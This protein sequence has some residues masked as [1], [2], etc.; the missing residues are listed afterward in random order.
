MDVFI[1]QTALHWLFHL[2]HTSLCC[3]HSSMVTD[4]AII[5]TFT[6]FSFC[7]SL[8]SHPWHEEVPRLGVESELQLPAQ[9]TAY[10]TAMWDPSH[11]CEL[12]LSS[13]QRRILIHRARPRI[14]PE[15]SWML[16]GFI[17]RWA[18]MGTC[19]YMHFSRVCA[20]IYRTDQNLW[21][22]VCLFFLA[23]PMAC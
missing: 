14:K 10:T 16:V 15:S 4:W 17:N 3:R 13:W 9:A 5:H 22:C 20:F 8:G 6:L 23:M 2:F 21:F 7:V 18:R 12:H 1:L 11:V 19:T